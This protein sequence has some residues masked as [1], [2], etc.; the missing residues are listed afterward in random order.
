MMAIFP[1]PLM[2]RDKRIT[3]KNLHCLQLS[4]TWLNVNKI[5]I[6]FVLKHESP[7]AKT[8]RQLSLDDVSRYL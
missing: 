5:R 6:D 7:L 8:R 3:E 1:N 4:T 2:A